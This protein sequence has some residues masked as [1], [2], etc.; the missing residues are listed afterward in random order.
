M[1]PE[2]WEWSLEFSGVWAVKCLS[3]HN[4]RPSFM[5]E[6]LC[7]LKLLG[8]SLQDYQEWYS[9]NLQWLQRS[10]EVW[11]C[12]EYPGLSRKWGYLSWGAERSPGPVQ[13]VSVAGGVTSE[14][15]VIPRIQE[16]LTEM[17]VDPKHFGWQMKI[18][19]PLLLK[20]KV[21]PIYQIWWYKVCFL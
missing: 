8:I 3:V 16:E 19:Y 10:G 20:N 5:S 12:R 14:F 21:M 17:N 18:F 13:D 7:S 6:L 1:I 2:C 9:T 11:G 4:I 15:L